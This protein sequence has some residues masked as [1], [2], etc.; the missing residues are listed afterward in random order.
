MKR[1]SLYLFLC[2]ALLFLGALIPTAPAD[3]GLAGTPDYAAK[4]TPP[5]NTPATTGQ[6][7]ALQEQYQNYRNVDADYRHAGPEALER[8]QDWKWGLRIHWGLYCMYN[9]RESWIIKERFA[10]KDF[11]K[12]YYTSYQRF[13]PVGFDADEWMAILQRAGMKYFSFTTKHH[14]GFC[15]WPTKT[16]QRGLFK[17]PDGSYKDVV[18]NFSIMDAPY[19][20]DIVGA[21]VKSARSHGLGVSLYFS[22]IDWHDWDFGWD[23]L[24]TWNDGKFN[25]KADD[26]QRWAAALKK[27]RDQLTE[28]LT[29]YGPIDTLCLD[30][31]WPKE[32]QEDINDLARMVRKLQPGIMMRN[33]GI[34]DYGDYETPERNVPE[35]PSKVKRPW[36][37][38][39]PGG[40]NFSYKANDTYKSKEWLLESLIDIVAKGGNFQVGFGPAPD[41]T[42]PPE[43]IAMVNY[44]GDWLKVNG[45]AIYATRP[46]L[47]YHEGEDLR[48]TRSKDKKYLYVISL[49]WPGETL[50]THMVL[51]RPGSKIRMI[52]VDEDLPWTQDEV[53]GLT[54]QIPTSDAAKKTCA[55]AYAFKIESDDWA[56]LE[57]KLPQAQPLAVKGNSRKKGKSGGQGKSRVDAAAVLP[58]VKLNP[59]AL[60]INFQPREAAVPKGFLADYGE[61]LDDRGNGQR[62]GWSAD[63][64]AQTRRRGADGV[65]NTFCHFLKGANWRIA[66][67]DG[68]YAVTVGVGDAGFESTNTIDV[69]GVHFCREL[70]LD[71]EVR[72]ITRTVEVKG[73]VLTIDCGES[74][75]RSTKITYAIIEKTR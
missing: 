40:T 45:E 64:T 63:H 8:W 37:V 32:A 15:M 10:D 13:N 44:V 38:I 49:K 48:F 16:T 47:R 11:L 66:V 36:Q 43:M 41:G 54:I 19:K 23:K 42:W 28:L 22:H 18:N 2:G 27:E 21:L 50:N 33:R 52:G 39:Y 56:K 6:E 34:G 70:T 5:L 58:I 72:E 9:T 65:S 25:T 26:P 53:K 60:G 24:S 62:Y 4:V 69:A 74:Q 20:K 67:A 51:A 1:T 35:D 3:P 17:N 57:G 46:Y 71:R 29:W 7:T 31:S 75:P 12:E 55:Q 14:E 73:G 30:M 68:R 59:G 61:A